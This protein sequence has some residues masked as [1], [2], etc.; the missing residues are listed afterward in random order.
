MN[1]LLWKYRQLIL[2]V[3]KRVSLV[4]REWRK[5]KSEWTECNNPS[6]KKDSLFFRPIFFRF[7][8]KCSFMHILWSI[9]F[10]THPTVTSNMLHHTLNPPPLLPECF[11]FTS[12]QSYSLFSCKQPFLVFNNCESIFSHIAKLNYP[13]TLFWLSLF[14]NVLRTDDITDFPYKFDSHFS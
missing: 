3:S 13:V 10:E 1:R 11:R 14:R 5:I 8:I 9:W 4:A 7:P 6:L 12:Y 2:F